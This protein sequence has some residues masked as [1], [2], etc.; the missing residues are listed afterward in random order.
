MDI[1]QYRMAR[2]ALGWDVS[3][4]CSAAG[5]DRRAVARFEE[6]SLVLPGQLRAMRQAFEGHGIEFIDDGAARGAVRMAAV[7]PHKAGKA[8]NIPLAVLGA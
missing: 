4:L 8:L 6:G 3:A 2:A 7:E 1:V 5:I